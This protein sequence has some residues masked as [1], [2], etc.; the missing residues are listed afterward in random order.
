MVDDFVI[1]AC[2]MLCILGHARC[3]GKPNAK[4]AYML[5]VPDFGLMSEKARG[6][7]LCLYVIC[8]C[9]MCLLL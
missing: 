2:Y 4:L 6:S 9:G 5:C 1:H 3:R 8:L 7:L